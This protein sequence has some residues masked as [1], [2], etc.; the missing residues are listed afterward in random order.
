[1]MMKMNRL[2]LVHQS[3]P[4]ELV[5]CSSW[6]EL[7]W[8]GKI[9]A[10]AFGL[11]EGLLERSEG[12]QEGGSGSGCLAPRACPASGRHPELISTRVSC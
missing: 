7:V 11:V 9:W 8:L 2:H 4:Q 6:S 10:A 3:L 1:M 12:N 5:K